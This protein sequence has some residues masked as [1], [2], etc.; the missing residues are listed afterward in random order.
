MIGQNGNNADTAISFHHTTNIMNRKEIVGWNFKQGE[1]VTVGFN[2]SE[3]YVY[4]K[5][6]KEK[7]KVLEFDMALLAEDYAN[8]ENVYKLV[9]EYGLKVIVLLQNVGDQV[10]LIEA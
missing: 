8:R 10:T 1:V 3:Q 5:L 2:Y 6:H 4:F 7:G 9:E